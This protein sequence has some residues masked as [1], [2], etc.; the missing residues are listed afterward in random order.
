MAG[1]DKA[2]PDSVAIR[3]KYE[4]QQGLSVNE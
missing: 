1:L 3:D 2:F 4:N